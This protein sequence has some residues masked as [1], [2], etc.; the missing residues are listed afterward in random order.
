MQA[1]ILLSVFQ[2]PGVHNVLITV[3]G[4]NVKQLFDAS[5]TVGNDEPYRRAEF[6]R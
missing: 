1:Q 5:G 4:K 3:D 2:Y 6:Q